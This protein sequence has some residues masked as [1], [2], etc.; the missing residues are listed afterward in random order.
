[1]RIS[2]KATHLG[3][4]N[5]VLRIPFRYGVACLT[6]CPQA[7]LQ[8]K[9]ECSEGVHAGYSGDCLPPSW[10]DKSPER[11]F[12]QQITDMLT[13]ICLAESIFLEEAASPIEFFSAWSIVYERVQD[14]CRQLGLTPLLASFG[15]SMVERAVMDAMA[16]AAK[17]SFAR[18]VR[19]NLYTVRAGRDGLPLTSFDWLPARPLRRLYVRHTVGLSDPLTAVDVDGEW[20]NDGFP[21]TLEEYLQ[22]SGVR[23]FKIK[24]SNQLDHDLGRLL[25]IVRLVEKHRGT[26]YALTLDGNEQYKTAADFDTL[27]DAITA[28][29]ELRTMWNNV[30]AIEQPLHRGIA[31]EEAHTAGIRALAKRKPVIIDESDGDLDAYPR[32]V[33]LGY[34]GVSS[35]NCK[36]TLRSLMNARRTWELNQNPFL[37]SF[38]F[39]S[40]C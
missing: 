15:V 14:R 6:R 3:L 32:A 31:L 1:M 26:G 28:H 40:V 27:I 17:L 21:Y 18:A 37:G 10:F 8:V 24:V 20:L 22:R 35:K 19:S 33:E 23:Y 12:E 2:L 39:G 13:V 7:V 34:R 16:R 4:L 11:D 9:I 5:S 38:N 25:T 30:V 36:G 29:D